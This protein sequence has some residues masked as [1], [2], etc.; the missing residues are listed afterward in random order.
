MT[1]T[2]IYVLS[3]ALLKRRLLCRICCCCFHRQ[4]NSASVRN[5]NRRELHQW[6]AIMGATALPLSLP[7]FQNFSSSVPSSNEVDNILDELLVQTM[8]F[9]FMTQERLRQHDND[10]N[11][12][13]I[14]ND[15]DHTN[16]SDIEMARAEAEN[17][18]A[19]FDVISPQHTRRRRIVPMLNLHTKEYIDNAIVSQSSS[20]CL[21][22]ICLSEF[23]VGEVIATSS[24]TSGGCSHV[25]HEE[26]IK[27][28]LR[29]ENTCPLC[30]QVFASQSLEGVHDTQTMQD[31]TT[32]IGEEQRLRNLLRS[33]RF[34]RPISNLNQATSWFNYFLGAALDLGA[35]DD[36]QYEEVNNVQFRAI[37]IDN[38]NTTDPT[39][40]ADVVES[41][42]HEISPSSST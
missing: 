30:K 11:L 25:F 21:C 19:S 31:E 15:D 12:G 23:K 1:G 22:S 2:L 26:C 28:W 6:R 9:R 14:N 41:V 39:N 7:P 35:E 40:H 18:E 8:L 20:E 27:G 10:V 5:R 13:E 17:G 3:K 37:R 4:N 42:T 24:L 29:R 16:D 32:S 34:H 36:P 38:E 33:M